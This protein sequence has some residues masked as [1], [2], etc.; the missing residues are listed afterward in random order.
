MSSRRFL[1]NGVLADVV[2]S[3]KTPVQVACNKEHRLLFHIVNLGSPCRCLMQHGGSVVEF[4]LDF[5]GTARIEFEEQQPQDQETITTFVAEEL[6]SELNATEKE[7]KNDVKQRLINGTTS[8]SSHHEIAKPCV[9]G[10][11]KIDNVTN[12]CGVRKPAHCVEVIA[13]MCEI[14]SFE[15]CGEK[16]CVAKKTSKPRSMFACPRICN[17]SDINCIARRV[18]SGEALWRQ[19]AVSF[20]TMMRQLQKSP[21]VFKWEADCHRRTIISLND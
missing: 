7:F 21:S 14:N 4:G 19:C 20:S 17:V 13:A 8:T 12:N 15:S 2:V 16:L 10:A 18:S 11:A 5:A 1:F 3:R 9:Y 6:G